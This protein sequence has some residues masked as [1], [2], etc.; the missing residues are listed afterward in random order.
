MLAS[1]GHD[2]EAALL[3]VDV[4][5]TC[6]A[7]A[8]RSRRAS[9]RR[10][11]SLALVSL[12]L[13]VGAGTLAV[14]IGS[15]AKRCSSVQVLR[16]AP[17]LRAA[18]VRCACRPRQSPAWRSRAASGTQDDHLRRAYTRRTELARASGVETCVLGECV[19]FV[20]SV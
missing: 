20:F 7:R 14:R 18:H 10:A 8:E 12:A 19:I 11:G 6:A 15:D 1:A 16:A 9:T 13:L 17:G 2:Y 4:E 3:D 5:V